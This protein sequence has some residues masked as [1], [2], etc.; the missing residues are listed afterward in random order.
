MQ[1]E[2]S[3]KIL[4]RGSALQGCLPSRESPPV[5]APTASAGRRRPPSGSD[6]PSCGR[7]GAWARRGRRAVPAPLA[8][9][10]RDP[11]HSTTACESIDSRPPPRLCA[12]PFLYSL[13]P[14][15]G[16]V[17]SSCPWLLAYP[18]VHRS[19]VA[20]RRVGFKLESGRLSSSPDSPAIHFLLH[21]HCF[22]TRAGLSAG[23]ILFPH[24]LHSRG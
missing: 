14:A 5:W 24:G 13:R 4:L 15:R 9:A 16:P 19:L 20:Q 23:S 2:K 3:S 7:E 21:A 17:A 11:P 6:V 8:T 18:P 10:F 22:G 1:I 12:S